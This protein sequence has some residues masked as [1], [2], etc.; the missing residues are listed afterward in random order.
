MLVLQSRE[1]LRPWV[2]SEAVSLAGD[3]VAAKTLYARLAPFAGR[4]AIA[5]NEGSVGIVDRYLGL[6][7]ATMGRLDDAE[8][9]LAA[10]IPILD[11]MGARP[12]RAHAEHDLAK[13]LRL[14][15][16]PGDAERAAALDRAAV[17][18]ASEIGM[19]FAQEIGTRSAPIDAT[20]LDSVETGVDPP[21]DGPSGMHGGS[22]AAT[23]RHESNSHVPGAHRRVQRRSERPP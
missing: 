20:G 15:G 6:L 23:F 8:G 2:D 22:F 5:S 4:H 7:A 10:A 1:P 14:R 17:A 9:H 18:A 19:A 11:A 13:V 12:W 21:Q 3:A 16:A